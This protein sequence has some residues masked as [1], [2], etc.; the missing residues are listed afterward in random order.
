MQHGAFVEHSFPD[1]GRLCVMVPVCTES[2]LR[3]RAAL[4]EEPE[5]EVGL[6]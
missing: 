3:F 2:R 4:R 6:V 1:V 5:V